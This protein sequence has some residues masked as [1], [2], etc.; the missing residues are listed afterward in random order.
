LNS[1]ELAVL[2]S[3]ASDAKVGVDAFRPLSHRDK[4][5]KRFLIGAAM[6][7][8][9]TPLRGQPRPSTVGRFWNDFGG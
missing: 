2:E 4:V 5:T 6:K 8:G 1:S 9:S 7:N 3:R